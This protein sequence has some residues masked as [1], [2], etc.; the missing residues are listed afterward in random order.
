MLKQLLKHS[1]IRI[2]AA[3][4]TLDLLL[5]AVIDPRSANAL[6]LIAAYI[7]VGLTILSLVQVVPLIIK[8]TY[9]EQG[10]TLVRRAAWYIGGALVLVL[11]LQSMGQ[12]TIRDVITLLPFA[13]IAYF[14]V[15][16][17]RQNA[18]QTADN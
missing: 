16:Y 13:L 7:L 8:L 17:G 2:S 12:L 6:W 1:I 9:G 15:T 18:A 10:Y 3:L 11:G 14:Y 5:F 4:I